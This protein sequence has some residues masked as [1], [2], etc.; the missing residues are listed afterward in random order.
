MTR[1]E[2]AF[3]VPRGTRTPLLAGLVRGTLLGAVALG[4]TVACEDPGARPT[5]TVQATD[6]AD[7]VLEGFSHWVTQDGIRRSEVQADTAYFY[8]NTQLTQ[9]RNVRV[10]FYDLNGKES[11]TLTS[12]TGTYRWQDGSMQANGKVVV[13]S[14]DGRKLQT[15]TLKYDNATNT[16]STNTHFIMDRGSDHLE[17]QSFRSDPDF[18]NVVTDKP[19]GRAGDGL[20]LPGQEKSP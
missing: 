7:Q 17:G 6:S 1:T 9:L 3:R 15:D 11:S 20:L 18:K 8:E 5:T 13:I 19:V 4:A 12:K 10:V 14:P 2:R 16:I